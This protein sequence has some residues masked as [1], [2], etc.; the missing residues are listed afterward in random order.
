MWKSSATK[1]PVRYSAG[2]QQIPFTAANGGF[3]DRDW[4]TYRMSVPF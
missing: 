1:L 3:I 4:A 2:F